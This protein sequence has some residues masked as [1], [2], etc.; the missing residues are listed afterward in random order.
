MYLNILQLLV[1]MELMTG[2]TKSDF[3]RNWKGSK[4][5]LNE[6]IERLLAAKENVPTYEIPGKYY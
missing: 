6:N 1:E 3:L 5:Q 4:T 2:C